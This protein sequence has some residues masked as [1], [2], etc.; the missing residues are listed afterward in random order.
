MRDKWAWLRT[1]GVGTG[2]D[3]LSD[4]HFEDLVLTWHFIVPN[5]HAPLPRDYFDLYAC[6]AGI[7]IIISHYGFEKVLCVLEKTTAA[8]FAGRTQT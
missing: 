2:S 8:A 1:G 5:A 6:L 3:F 4:V 7:F